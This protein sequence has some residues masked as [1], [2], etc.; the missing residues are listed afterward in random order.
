MVALLLALLVSACGDQT[1]TS[2]TTVSPTTAAA[3]VSGTTVVST[4]VAASTAAS[5]TV[6]GTTAPATTAATTAAVTTAASTAAAA[7]PSPTL[8]PGYFQNPVLKE[9]FPDPYILKVGNT[10]Y[11]YATNAGGKKIQVTSSTDLV[12]WKT[13]VEALPVLPPWA[14]INSGLVWAP[15]V[16][17]IGDHFNLYF[18]ARDST[19]DKQCVGLATGTQPDNFSSN[20]AQPFVCHPQDGGDI[21]QDIFRDT[22]GKLYL[23][24]K[25]D[26]NCCGLAT[27]I[28]V[29]E[30]TPDGLNLTGQPK[31]LLSND[32]AWEG[33][34]IEAPSMFKHDNNYYLFF[35]GN[36]YAGVEY[37][38]GYATCQTALGP[39]QQASENP[40]LKSKLDKQPVVIGPGHQ[41]LLQVGNQ[42]WMF[43][44]AWEVT[45]S[46]KGDRRLMW[47]DKVNWVNGKPVVQG[48]T[49][50][51]QPDPQ[52]P[53]GS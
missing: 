4:T 3:T 2:G 30:L 40:I 36:N 12:H 10:F 32:A 43:Y 42:T 45:S 48:P 19:S 7:Q 38:V 20:S 15:E 17:Q 18:T 47:M 29:Q 8:A 31:E 44:H 28:Y 37:A 52:I 35:S 14:T 5:T 21:D 49:T 27:H 6:A 33:A 16:T 11:A 39:C 25:N 41:A 13:P 26:G 9:D 23:Y 50:S 46:G 53:T 34:V 51:P 1:T 24:F 22:D